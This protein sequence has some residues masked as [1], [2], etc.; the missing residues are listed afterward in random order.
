MRL[1]V[2]FMAADR[3]DLAVE[4]C[5]HILLIRHADTRIKKKAKEYLDWISK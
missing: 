4:A 5:E 1:A 3:G 2:I